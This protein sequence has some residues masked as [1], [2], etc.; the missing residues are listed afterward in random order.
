MRMSDPITS[1]LQPAI[2][3]FSIT[4]VYSEC[5][6]VIQ[7]RQLTMRFVWFLGKSLT[8]A[9]NK[10]KVIMSRDNQKFYPR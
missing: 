1:L 10:I 8:Y 5:R 3:Y 9:T 7:L 4:T 6:A 2:I